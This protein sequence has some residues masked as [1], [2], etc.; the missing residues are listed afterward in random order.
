MESNESTCVTFLHHVGLAGAAWKNLDGLNP[1]NPRNPRN[2]CVVMS[3]ILGTST[4]WV[5]IINSCHNPFG[6]PKSY[7]CPNFGYRIHS[8][9][10]PWTLAFWDSY[11][12]PS[13]LRM[14]SLTFRDD[15]PRWQ[16]WLGKYP[17]FWSYLRLNEFPLHPPW[18]MPMKNTLF[19]RLKLKYVKIPY[20][21][22][23]YNYSRLMVFIPYAH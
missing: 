5:I 1:G 12:F 20:Q 8:N 3:Q 11:L 15:L 4:H 13:I 23:I 14:T 9:S 7:G 10:L 17:W 2:P 22:I 6:Y 21:A 18:N 16:R 19:L